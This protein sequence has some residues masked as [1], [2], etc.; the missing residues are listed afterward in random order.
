MIVSI[1]KIYIFLDDEISTLFHRDYTRYIF[2]MSPYFLVN[3]SV[4]DLFLMNDNN[5]DTIAFM[6]ILI[7]E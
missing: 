4:T 1:I 7:M 5:K 2:S 3:V 6:V